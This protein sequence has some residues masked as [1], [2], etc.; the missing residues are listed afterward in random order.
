MA[1]STLLAEVKLALRL[2]ETYA[3]LDSELTDNIAEAEA[4]MERLGITVDETNP[5]HK[6]LIKTY[7]KMINTE[8]TNLIESYRTS[9]LYQLDCLSKT[10]EV[11][12]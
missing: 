5:L 9:W 1:Q 11:V 6:R 12:E 3:A 8:E 10:S 2:P 7:C 4:E